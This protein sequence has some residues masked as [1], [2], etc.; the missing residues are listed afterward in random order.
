[1]YTIPGYHS[2]EQLY[3]GCNSLVYRARRQSD[4]HPVILKL[5]KDI[6]P[7]PERIAWFKRE[8]EVTSNLN[9]VR[10]PRV[11]D[12]QTIQQRWV[13]IM[14]DF[15]GESLTR[16]GLVG[17]VS[18]DEF[19]YLAREITE[20]LGEIHQQHIMHKDI[21]PSN[22]VFNPDT[23]EVKIIDFGIS[24]VLSRENPTFR[25][26]NVLEGTLAYM[27]PE[28]T[29][30][31]NRSMDYRTDFYSLGATLYELLTGHLPFNSDDALELVHYHIAR[32][33]EPPH[34]YNP[35]IP[36]ALSAIILKLMAKNAED[37]YQSFYGI[38]KDL[39]TVQE[40][41]RS[42]A[43]ISA[44]PLDS[45][46]V[47]CPF[48]TPG[49]HDI[50]DRFLI[51]QKLY[52]RQ[53]EIEILLN[54]FDRIAHGSSEM[55]LVTGAAGIGKTA[56]VQELYKPITRQ[57]GYVIS[58]KFDQFQRDIPYIA[59]IQA[60]RSL[61]Q[62]ILTESDEQIA[63]WRKKLLAAIG[64]NGQ[65]IIEVIPEIELIIGAQPHVPD[66]GP[67]ETQNRFNLVFQHFIQV[68]TQPEHPLV[69]FLDDVQW[70]DEASLYMI[71]QLLTDTESHNLLLILA[72]RNSEVEASHPLQMTIRV[73]EQARGNVHH[74]MLAPLDIG[75]VTRIVC[76][77]LH[78]TEAKA[79]PL[80]EL[81]VVKTDGNPF[82]LQEFLTS[83]YVEAL[84]DF[85]HEL[86]SWRWNLGQI[87]AQNITDNVVELMTRKVLR[88]S[89]Q[90]QDALKLAACIGNRFDL[91]KLAVVLQKPVSATAGDLEQAVM[92]G[93]IAPIGNTYKLMTLDV[94]GLS[95]AVTA[96]YVFTH[97]RIQ[98]AAYSLIPEEERQ[99]VH[100]RIGYL[101]LLDI[102]PEKRED[103]IFDIVN[104]L[105]QGWAFISEQAERDELAELNLMAGKKAKASAA[106]EPAFKYFQIG[107][108]L[109]NEK[110]PIADA[111]WTVSAVATSPESELLPLPVDPWHYQYHL[112][113]VLHEEAAEAAYLSG[114]FEHME[115]LADVVLQKA[116]S[117]LDRAKV[118]EV[119]IRAY[120]AQGKHVEA[121]Q[122]ALYVLNLLGIP[123]REHPDQDDSVAGLQE[124]QQAL[125]GKNLDDLATLAPMTD[126]Y[127]LA[128]MRILAS[129]LNAAYVASPELMTLITFKMITLSVNYGSTPL[130]AHAYASYGLLLCGDIGDIDAGYRFGQI[131]LDLLE[132]FNARELKPRTLM[133]VNNFIRH[134]KEHAR[135][136]LHPL[137][138]AYH[139][140][141]ETGDLE[142]AAIAIYVYSSLSFFTGRPLAQLEQEM[143]SYSEVLRRFR[144]KRAWY[145]NSLFRQV[146]LNLLGKS[147]STCYLIGDCY[148]EEK[149]LPLHL[150]DNDRTA[151]FYVH[152][153]KLILFYLFGY[154]DMAV[155]QATLA[156][157]YVRSA[158]AAFSIVLF[159]FY[160]SLARLALIRKQTQLY[161]QQGNEDT[162]DT[163]T[164]EPFQEHLER[165][166]S[167][168]AKLE[169]WTHHA[170]MNHLHKYYLVEAEYA[171]VLGND[172]DAR[173]YYDRAID[174]A[175]EYVYV[176]EEAIA[177]ELAAGFYF[178]RAR[179]R[180]GSIYLHDAR[181]AYQRW[182]AVAKVHA[183]DEQYP[184]LGN[185]SDRSFERRTRI[186]TSINETEERVTSTLDV[187]SVIKASQAIFGEIVLEPLLKKLMHIF[188]ENAGAQRGALLMHKG[189]QWFIEAEHHIDTNDVAIL[190][191][192]SLANAAIP[193]PLVLYVARM[194]ESVVLQD[195]SQPEEW[196][197]I[198]VIHEAYIQ[199]YHPQSI[200]CMPL[201][202]EK[203]LIGILYL[204]NNL[205]I[206]A[207]TDKRVE[208]L[209]LLT[210]QA[211]ISIVHAH[212]YRHMEDLIE[213]RTAEL[214]MAQ[215]S[216]DR[217]A[218]GIAWYGPGGEYLYVNDAACVAYGFSREELLA[219]TIMDMDPGLTLEAWRERWNEY[220]RHGSLK[221]ET[222]HH[223]KDGTSFPVEVSMTFLE[224]NEHEYLCSFIRDITE[225]KQA[226]T[227]LQ[228]AKEVAE[229][230]NRTKSAFLANMS[231]ELRTPLNAILGFTQLMTRDHTL[232][233]SHQEKLR[234]VGRSGEHLLALINDILEMSKIEAG[235]VILNEH[236]FD[237]HGLIQ[238]LADMFYLRASDKGLTLIVEQAP[239]IPPYIYSDESRIRQVLI[240][241]LGNAIKFTE[242]GTVTL[243]A[244]QG[245]DLDDPA[246][247]HLRFEVEDTGPGIEPQE[248]PFIFEAFTQTESGTKANEGTGLG[249]PISQQF[250]H[251]MG[252]EITVQSQPGA[253]ACFRFDI[254]VQ[255]SDASSVPTRKPAREV[256][257][258]APDQPTY[259][260]L[261]VEDQRD[262]RQ[263]MVELLSSLGFDVCEVVNGKEALAIWETYSPHIIFMDMRMPVMDGYETTRRIKATA[264][265]LNTPVV[266]LTASAF[267]EKRLLVLATGCDEYI[268]KPF[269]QEEIFDVLVR[270]VG[271][272]F[273]YADDIVKND[274]EP[275]RSRHGDARYHFPISSSDEVLTSS[276]L[277]ALHEHI[278]TEL[279]T[280]A[281]LGDLDM[282]QHVVEQ[283]YEHNA[284]LARELYNLVDMFRFDQI[285]MLIEGITE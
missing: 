68:F 229:T 50:S 85:D 84:I 47:T 161:Q 45:V 158:V 108:K 200:L 118:Y 90:S 11:Y 17:A 55:M 190:K 191:S 71:E 10:V 196:G 34:K 184:E 43:G 243:R 251:M 122:T 70:A 147:T 104:Q 130:A 269:R 42:E 77:T 166:R 78:C 59:L 9:L 202:Y 268:R 72:Y 160:D 1:M 172:R 214:R 75:A 33:P 124:A 213:A 2:K 121:V 241:L 39:E 218:D 5:L 201:V 69:L 240:N 54:A 51:P 234:I 225:R 57:R 100:W 270:F 211:A 106:Y 128:A 80:A 143:V 246:I 221:Y 109:L 12:L 223:R 83:L 239:D 114:N 29:G 273:V 56:L 119:K 155:E 165:V 88:L 163:S 280:A 53:A 237:L 94:P 192:V 105:N 152:F 285:A 176:N 151:I 27:S 149:M 277:A 7:S 189:G 228:Q 4:N 103:H 253:G 62:Y 178:E 195:A 134:W 40:Q 31:M 197:M 186:T 226:E 199:Q 260:I 135:A 98:Q 203:E 20:I 244:M 193:Q 185:N 181:Y 217:S 198:P 264:Q 263:L 113:L 79:R 173:E 125:E 162:P 254:P 267:E 249:L 174:L 76:E 257:G 107:I 140:G 111:P 183:L 164:L 284:P 271:A 156:E 150:L 131:A 219:K 142:F 215:F 25:N 177:C 46:P 129:T 248:I 99:S 26:P 132:R 231:H 242:K 204:E 73:I 126:P 146:V 233:E 168:Q 67:S 245:D 8:Y 15:G 236:H 65:V 82:F 235:R 93:L 120:I 74:L 97:D 157:R 171:R 153:N 101:L 278:I 275:D 206:G 37:R 207:F 222:Y 110:W 138:E 256:I 232:S 22:V 58:G 212:L 35:Y 48:F 28:Q 141:M 281:T 95:E 139:L 64:G 13:M 14:D 145:M 252:G 265:G 167:N 180:I 279:Y 89:E 116:Q 230:A 216:L 261:V 276:D 220:R 238:D 133:L 18:L 19:F 188:I 16:L 154:C 258:L 91:V 210:N 41:I 224:F 148:D 30:R 123:F 63:H 194:R 262:S 175:Q 182:G 60:F 247:F 227:K 205:T 112:T 144:Q 137:L 266:A 3:E 86:R 255:V 250:I 102:R 36:P 179:F 274:E 209:N 66:L 283:I 136:T 96:E 23:N 169:Q 21:T 44:Q 272:R 282:M 117:V 81:L 92:E 24:A 115:R 52:G 159:Y 87:E 127:K 170:P 61:V 32:Q 6:Y 259:R 38:K 49:Q 187:V 208:I